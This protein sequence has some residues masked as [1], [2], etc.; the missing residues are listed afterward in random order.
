M[1][2][3]TDD[4]RINLSSNELLHPEADRLVTEALAGIP[5]SAVRR[6]PVT[7]GAIKDI[8]ASLDVDPT[9]LWLT[10]GSDIALRAVAGAYAAEPRS[11]RRLVLQHPN[12]PAW[13]EAARIS[14]LIV[15]RVGIEAGDPRGQAAALL[16]AA[17]SAHRCLIAVSVPNGPGGWAIEDETLD[18]LARLAAEREHLLVI[19]ACYQAF[20]GPL[21]GHLYRRAP[22]V[23]VVQSLSKS[24]GLA[25]ARVALVCGSRERIDWIAGTQLEQCVSGASVQLARAALSCS[26][27]FE[28]VWS[29]IA[30]AREL[31][32]THLL[33][34]GLQALPSRANFVAFR[35]GSVMDASTVVEAMSNAGYRIRDLSLIEPLRGCVRFTIADSELTSEV[36]HALDIA[37]ED[38][39]A[40]GVAARP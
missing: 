14:G 16:T 12:Y 37:V 36:L 38:M 1:K 40:V 20:H 17:R 24:H 25:G 15:H 33:A 31:A 34:Q 39:R 9:E 35:I 11:A 19:D 30:A 8:S 22:H 27:A 4:P 28:E 29:E 2:R 6:Y 10:P 21:T 3:R 18:E 23:L 13:E 26:E 32:V 7:D 5:A